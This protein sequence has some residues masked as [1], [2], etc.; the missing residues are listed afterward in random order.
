[1]GSWEELEK[2][3]VAN[4]ASD[5]QVSIAGIHRIDPIARWRDCSER[6]S[7]SG[8][9]FLFPACALQLCIRSAPGSQDAAHSVT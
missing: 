3:I 8:R 7:R 2:S 6:T 5:V 4:I 1:M 9:F